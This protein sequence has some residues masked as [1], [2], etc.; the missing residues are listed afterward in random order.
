MNGGNFTPDEQNALVELWKA[1]ID[2]DYTQTDDLGDA[3]KAWVEKRKVVDKDEKTPEIYAERS[4]GGYDFFPNCTKNAFET[5]TETLANRISGHSA[6]DPNVVE[7]VKGQDQVFGNC[8][9]G[10]QMPDDPPTGAPEWLQK[11][12]PIKKRQPR[13]IRSIT[14][15]QSA[16][17]TRSHRIP[18]RHGAKLLTTLSPAL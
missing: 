11:T 6:T 13:S 14:G 8:S 10:K 2:R 3:L 16:D 12:G 9:S 18:R 15:M 1:E 7:W 5:A 4:Y 17:L